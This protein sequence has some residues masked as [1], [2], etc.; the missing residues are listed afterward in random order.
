MSA[1]WSG[2]WNFQHLARDPKEPGFG[3]TVDEELIS[4]LNTGFFVFEPH[5]AV[6]RSQ[7][8]LDDIVGT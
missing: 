4:N 7:Y 8:S 6:V 2:R 1:C 3:R 5:G